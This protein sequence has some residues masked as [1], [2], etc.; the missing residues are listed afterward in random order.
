MHTYGHM[1]DRRFTDEL[2]RKL[3]LAHTLGDKLR[4]YKNKSLNLLTF[5]LKCLNL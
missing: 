4:L 5:L 2:T 1:V 3:W